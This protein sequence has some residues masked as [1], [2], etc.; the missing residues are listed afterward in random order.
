M[1]ASW[2][3]SRPLDTYSHLVVSGGVL[4][5]D[6]QWLPIVQESMEELCYQFKCPVFCF[7]VP[8]W[9]SCLI[10]PCTHN[11]RTLRYNTT[12]SAILM[13][14]YMWNWLNRLSHLHDTMYVCVFT[15]LCCVYVLWMTPCSVAKWT[16]PTCR[17]ILIHYIGGAV[18]CFGYI[19]LLFSAE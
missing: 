7:S 16:T 17:W 9:Q 11:F 1:V 4:V 13:R 15:C 19:G 14:T 3:T 5:D 18:S 8:R 10:L 12:R 2:R 6:L